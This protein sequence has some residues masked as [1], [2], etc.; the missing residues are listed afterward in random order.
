MNKY[1][2]YDLRPRVQGEDPRPQRAEDNGAVEMNRSNDLRKMCELPDNE[3]LGVLARQE[4]PNIANDLD[5]D[6][7]LLEA[8]LTELKSCA[9]SFNHRAKGWCPHCSYENLIAR[10]DERLEVK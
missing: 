9:V 5:A 10:L 3:A 8:C 4:L 2:D 7:A 1:N 6:T